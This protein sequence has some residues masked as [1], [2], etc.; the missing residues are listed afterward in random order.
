MEDKGGA[1]AGALM[2]ITAQIF[3]WISIEGIMQAAVYGAIGAGAGFM[4][5]RFLKWLFKPLKPNNPNQSNDK[6]SRQTHSS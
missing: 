6:G 2:S 5:T 4:M 1:I 3:G